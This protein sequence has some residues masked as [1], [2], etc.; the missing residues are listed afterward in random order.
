MLFKKFKIDKFKLDNLNEQQINNLKKMANHCNTN[1]SNFRE[2]ISINLVG[3]I[4][5]KALLTIWGDETSIAEYERY[6]S[7]LILMWFPYMSADRVE[8]EV[9]NIRTRNSININDIV[10]DMKE[11]HKQLN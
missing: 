7:K 3:R 4:Q 10:K 1:E 11:L 9:K 8:G 5:D 6:A 2:N